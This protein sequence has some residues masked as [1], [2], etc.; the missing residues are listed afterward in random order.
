M[1]SAPEQSTQSSHIPVMVPE[2]LDWLA[3]RPDGVYV[4]GTLGGGGHAREILSRLSSGGRLIGLDR[5]PA[6]LETARRTFPSEP[7]NLSLYH[8]SYDTLEA[9]LREEGLSVVNGIL[10][11]LG[12]SS[13]QLNDAQ[14][15]FSFQSEGTLDMRFD[16][17]DSSSSTVAQFISHSSESIL[18][19]TIFEFGED[20]YARR[21]ARAIK[22]SES[23]ETVQDL[24]EA[25][26]RST[27]PAQRN[28]SFAR[29]FQALRIV[30]NSELDCLNRFLSL[31]PQWLA[32]GGR[33]VIL[34]YHSL[35]DR[36]V[37]HTF[38]DYRQH[39]LLNILTKKPV[40][41]PESE[42]AENRRAASAKLRAAEKVS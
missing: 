22:R 10:L 14:R 19:D 28:R 3:I 36:L 23:M 7:S 35:E 2:V 31:F 15:G 17:D 42:V 9:I 40:T 34:S 13:L 27:P 29:V 11:D 37:K 18:A 41:A 8:A 4:D 38:K 16:P 20:R 30:V 21:I 5:D 33:I 1:T 6:A 26:R 24:K 12:L 25:I 32:P 39:G